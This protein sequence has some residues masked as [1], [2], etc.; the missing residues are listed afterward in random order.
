MGKIEKTAL[1]GRNSQG[2]FSNSSRVVACWNESW[3]SARGADCVLTQTLL[4]RQN[5]TKL[6]FL[7]Y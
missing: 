3:G 7:L 2:E 1:F 6:S 5:K 4:S